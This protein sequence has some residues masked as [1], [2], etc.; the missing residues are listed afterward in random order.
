MPFTGVA[1]GVTPVPIVI[2]SFDRPDYLERLLR[3]LL[4]Q[5]QLRPDPGARA[6][7]LTRL[8]FPMSSAQVP[9]R[10]C[11]SALIRAYG[12][13]EAA[14]TVRADAARL[15]RIGSIELSCHVFHEAVG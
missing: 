15:L 10:C 13:D 8:Y 4:A 11:H 2:Y 3:G 9:S 6:P 5:T 12:H 1:P 14:P 7:Y